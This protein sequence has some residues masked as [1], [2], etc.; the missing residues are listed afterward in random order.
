M[1]IFLLI[2]ELDIVTSSV[3]EPYGIA[4]L[5]KTKF[6]ALKA[7]VPEEIDIEKL[8]CLEPSIAILRQHIF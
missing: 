3:Y 2:H 7:G 6:Q 1:W 4:A 8:Y 5:P